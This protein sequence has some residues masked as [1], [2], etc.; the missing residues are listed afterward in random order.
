MIQKNG[1]GYPSNIKE[2]ERVSEKEA[3]DI[4][5]ANILMLQK[6]V[7]AISLR[8]GIP[9]MWEEVERFFY[10]DARA[11]GVIHFDN[12]RVGEGERFRNEVELY[13]GLIYLRYK[14]TEVGC[15]VYTNV[16]VQDTIDGDEIRINVQCD[17]LIKNKLTS[18]SIFR[19]FS[20]CNAS[21]KVS[22]SN[23]IGKSAKR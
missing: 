10:K 5:Q 13:Y 19:T 11:N 12:I 22:K 2:L 23:R 9:C 8:L 7:N 15:M 18:I 16:S 6:G 20:V 3:H 1:M 21:F 17:D 14:C 4:I